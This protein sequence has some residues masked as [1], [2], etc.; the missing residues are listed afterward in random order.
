MYKVRII[1]DP[2]LRKPAAPIK[3][4]DDKL[5]AFIDEMAEIMY[6]KD[7]IGL[8]A[9]QI[10]FD[11]QVIVVDVSPLEE[12]KSLEHFVNPQIVSGEGESIIEEGCLSVP[13]V[14]E[15]VTRPAIIGLIWQD[16]TGAKKEAA[17]DGWM[18]RAIQHEYD[19][20][21]GKLFVDYLSPLK[22]Q[23]L[24]NKALIPHKF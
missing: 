19:H 6:R 11:R 23:L 13:N 12:D 5:S 16:K 3:Q 9:P 14:R 8:A 22:K 1:G 15:N 2:I 21:I 20:L 10:G 18:A 4:F 24:I 7:G 17:F